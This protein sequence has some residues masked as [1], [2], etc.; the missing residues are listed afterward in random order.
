[1]VCVCVC[2][3]FCLKVPFLLRFRDS[4]KTQCLFHTVLSAIGLQRDSPQ[5]SSDTLR[6]LKK[7]KAKREQKNTINIPRNIVKEKQHCMV[8]INIH[9]TQNK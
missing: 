5:I 7:D 1:M 2:V 8:L 9:L 6:C 3:W 4:P